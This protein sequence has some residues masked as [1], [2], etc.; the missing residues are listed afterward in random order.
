MGSVAVVVKRT[1]S[2]GPMSINVAPSMTTD[3]LS[4]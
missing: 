1:R 4:A 3:G 2:A